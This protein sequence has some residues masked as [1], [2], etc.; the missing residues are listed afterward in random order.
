LKNK[1]V[2][3]IAL[4]FRAIA[5]FLRIDVN[6]TNFSAFRLI[7]GFPNYRNLSINVVNRFKSLF[8]K[9]YF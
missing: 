7:D 4:L 8:N 6:R 2:R 1:E 5:L 9:Y 3:A